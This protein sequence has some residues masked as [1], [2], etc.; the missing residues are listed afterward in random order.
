[1]VGTVDFKGRS[2][3]KEKE[4]QF[5]MTQ[6]QYMKKDIIIINIWMHLIIDFQM[7]RSIR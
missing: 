1:M 6:V 7:T 5:I 2:T 4:G 3:V